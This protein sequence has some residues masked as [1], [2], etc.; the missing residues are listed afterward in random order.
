MRLKNAAFSLSSAQVACFLSIED[1]NLSHA[2][3]SEVIGMAPGCLYL[4]S[5]AT[6]ERALSELAIQR[7]LMGRRPSLHALS[8]RP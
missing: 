3:S 8:L 5:T 4:A 7:A 1:E 6:G 2:R